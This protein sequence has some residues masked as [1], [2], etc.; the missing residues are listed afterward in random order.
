MRKR[1]E[2]D[3]GRNVGIRSQNA[4]GERECTVHAGQKQAK[5]SSNATR[6]TDE[7]NEEV[8]YKKKDE[9][10]SFYQEA[11]ERSRR[12]EESFGLRHR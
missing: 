12:S 1:L 3:V 2:Q 11:E 4:R 7:S 10:F 8:V 6:H 9:E 5:H